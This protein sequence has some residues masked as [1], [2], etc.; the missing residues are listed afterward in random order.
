MCQ[1][2]PT[3][4]KLRPDCNLSLRIF[5]FLFIYS[6]LVVWFFGSSLQL[7]QETSHLPGV[8]FLFSLYL[9]KQPFVFSVEDTLIDASIKRRL[10][11][12]ATYLTKTVKWFKKRLVR[13]S[14]H[15]N[16]HSWLLF[17]V[18]LSLLFKNTCILLFVPNSLSGT[19][20]CKFWY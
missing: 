16:L 20:D 6:F 7:H 14:E 10:Q 8:P 5:L 17:Y 12:D 15:S 13:V 2:F 9:Y 3:Y 1:T 4:G 11:D 18:R 19:V